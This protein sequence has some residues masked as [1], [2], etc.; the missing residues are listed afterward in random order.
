MGASCLYPGFGSCDC[1]KSMKNCRGSAFRCFS[2]PWVGSGAARLSAAHGRKMWRT[3]ERRFARNVCS[4]HPFPPFLLGS[5]SIHSLPEAWG[6]W[7]RQYAP[8]ALHY[9]CIMLAKDAMPL[10]KILDLCLMQRSIGLVTEL[11]SPRFVTEYCIGCV[12]SHLPCRLLQ[13][14][15]MDSGSEAGLP[16]F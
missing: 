10:L 14:V 11:W 2:P 3:G 16:A 8:P 5:P 9:A 12:F 6:C 7:G 15:E 1:C 13:C 4:R